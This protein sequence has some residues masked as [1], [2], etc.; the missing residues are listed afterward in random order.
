[1]REE[2][3]EHMAKFVYHRSRSVIHKPSI[4]LVVLVICVRDI[5]CHSSCGAHVTNSL[6]QGQLTEGYRTYFGLVSTYCCIKRY[7]MLASVKL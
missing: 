7:G 2:G 3:K 1:M 6:Q 5:L 4:A